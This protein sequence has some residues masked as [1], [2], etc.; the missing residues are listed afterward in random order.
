MYLQ[1]LIRCDLGSNT[2]RDQSFLKE[3]FINKAIG[4]ALREYTRVD[5]E[6]VRAFVAATP[7]APLS[8]REAPK[9][10]VRQEQ[11]QAKKTVNPN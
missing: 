2:Y 3:F 7:L 6:G 10:L 8:A 9:W 1:Y 5:P 4:W 11:R